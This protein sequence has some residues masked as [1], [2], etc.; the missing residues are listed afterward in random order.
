[1]FGVGQGEFA[2]ALLRTWNESSLYLV[3]PYI[4]VW[5]D[6]ASPDDKTLQYLYETVRRDMFL[7]FGDS[8]H[9]FVRDFPSA[10]AA[11]WVEKRMPRPS[12][13]F[14]DGESSGIMEWYE[15]LAPGG[16]V[17]GGMS[18]L[19][20]ARTVFTNILIT[21]DNHWLAFKPITN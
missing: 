2:K 3:D 4:H 19:D 5:S 16:L 10:F 14:F 15:I 13:V 20:I 9:L 17:G 18:S 6:P 11:T 21:T 1:M 7:E 8:R 12:F